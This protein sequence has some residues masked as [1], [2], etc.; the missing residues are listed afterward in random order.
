MSARS[1]GQSGAETGFG[2][3][4]ITPS[5][6]SSRPP[7]C[8]IVQS[9]RRI[10]Q[11]IGIFNTVQVGRRPGNPHCLRFQSSPPASPHQPWSQALLCSRQVVQLAHRHQQAAAV[12]GAPPRAAL[13]A[14]GD[15][16][17]HNHGLQSRPA[18]V[19]R[20]QT[21]AAGIRARHHGGTAAAPC[22]RGVRGPA[23]RGHL[24]PRGAAAGGGPCSHAVSEQASRVARGGTG[25]G[26]VD[27][28]RLSVTCA[29]RAAVH[30]ALSPHGQPGAAPG[31]AQVA[32]WKRPPGKARHPADR[33]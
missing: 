14:R 7:P 17:W 24:P 29:A 11:R 10:G 9:P 4:Q 21:C 5:S 16:S 18:F 13:A 1:A 30:T 6:A 27:M 28:M 32:T 3:L 20:T 15:A 19:P 8:L 2:Q 12:A 26:R 33:A 22:P 23:E 25:S 31:M